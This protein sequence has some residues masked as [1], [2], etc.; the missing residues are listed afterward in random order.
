M[1]V[2]ARDSETCSC[3]Q[4]MKISFVNGCF[5]VLHPGH[6]ELLKYARSLGDYLIVAID[7]D[8]KVAEMKGPERPIFS[9]HDRSTML[10]AIRYVDVIHVFDTKEE[11]E[12]LLESISPDIMVV[13]SDWKGKE[14]VGSQYAKSV[15]FFDRLGDYSTT[16]TVKG[17]TYR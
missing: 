16:Q 1:D 7:S 9:Q 12:D 13:G 5:D 17:V 14:V 4:R 11:L 2:S 10:A 15:R 6:I 8:R 3:T